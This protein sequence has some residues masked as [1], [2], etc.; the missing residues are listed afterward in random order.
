MV[1]KRTVVYALFAIIMLSAGTWSVTVQAS[2]DELCLP[3]GEIG[4]V[5]PEGVEAKRS[6]VEFPHSQHF[7]YNCKECH[8]KWTGNDEIQGCMAGG[9]HDLTQAP[10]K[11]DAEPVVRYYKKAY[12]QMC[13]NCHK[14]LAQQNEK[15]E[16]AQGIGKT[17]I[18]PTGPTGCIECHPKE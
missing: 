15:A 8:H 6:P 9:C 16:K 13:I 4:L 7:A 10:K 17:E 3:L 5:P 11:G 12:H 1:T 2:D 14:T 18:V